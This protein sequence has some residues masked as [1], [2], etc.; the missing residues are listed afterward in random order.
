M[1]HHQLCAD[2]HN[3]ADSLNHHG[4][5]EDFQQRF[6]QPVNIA[7]KLTQAEFFHHLL[8]GEGAAGPG[9]QRHAGKIARHF[10]NTDHPAAIGRVMQDK[11]VTADFHQHQKVIEIP[12]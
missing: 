11:F 5:R 1:I 4:E 6:F 3:Q 8:P 12:V 7:D 10:L 9:F 2:R